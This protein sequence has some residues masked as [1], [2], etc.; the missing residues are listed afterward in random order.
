MSLN[1]IGEQSLTFNFF[2]HINTPIK[3]FWDVWVDFWRQLR[4]FRI[5]A[6]FVPISKYDFGQ[7]GI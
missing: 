2:S 5:F 6:V 1:D 4:H 3:C 7:N